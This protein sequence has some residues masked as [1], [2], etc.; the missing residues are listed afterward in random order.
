MSPVETEFDR[1]RRVH[2]ENANRLFESAMLQEDIIP[3]HGAFAR[4]W[5]NRE[6]PEGNRLLREAHQAIIKQENGTDV[7]T[8]EIASSE[9]VK[10]QMR[11]WNRIY[12]L[13]NDQS[14]FYPGRLD[15]ETQSMIEEMFW[16]YV[17]RMSRFERAGLK[18][19]WG[20]HGSENHEMMH[21]SNALLALQALK[22]R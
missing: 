13:F 11:T 10:W 1:I 3:L 8:A 21:Y 12:H 18:Y 20:I 22:N 2:G 9:H 6:L 14:R 17:G 7:M 5:L 16:L 4:F 15:E 19:I